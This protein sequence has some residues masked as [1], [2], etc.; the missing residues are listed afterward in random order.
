MAH[1]LKGVSPAGPG[2]LMALTKRS[3]PPPELGM[4]PSTENLDFDV[5]P[6]PTP[7]PHL[8]AQSNALSL[9]LEADPP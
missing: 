4:L 2:I 8:R 7:F 3:C 9:D 1:A 5:H 6:L